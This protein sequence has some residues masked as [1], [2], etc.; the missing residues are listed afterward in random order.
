MSGARGTRKHPNCTDEL[1]L[2][3][4]TGCCG[5]QDVREVT[6]KQGLLHSSRACR[7]RGWWEDQGLSSPS[8]PLAPTETMRLQTT[9][10]LTSQHATQ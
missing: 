10:I 9:S 4:E 1:R 2:G 3:A 6:V 7:G 5:G 8:S